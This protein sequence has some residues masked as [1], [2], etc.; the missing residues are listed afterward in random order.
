MM[1]NS[2]RCP[3][4]GFTALK[5]INFGWDEKGKFYIYRCECCGNR[6]QARE[7]DLKD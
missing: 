3:I 7:K 4:C 1:K 6:I 5:E 2:K